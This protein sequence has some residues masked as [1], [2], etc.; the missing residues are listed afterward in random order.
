MNTNLPAPVLL[1]RVTSADG[2][3]VRELYSPYRWRV[4]IDGAESPESGATLDSVYR[5]EFV[6]PAYGAPGSM[7]LHDCA[8]RLGGTV[9]YL[10]PYRFD[11][12]VVY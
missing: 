5:G 4:T 7:A 12:D 11:P 1:G 10:G 3:T 6:G 9:E 8:R 2:R